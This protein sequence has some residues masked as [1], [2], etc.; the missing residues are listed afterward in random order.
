M[1]NKGFVPPYDGKPSRRV[2]GLQDWVKEINKFCCFEIN[3][4][5]VN[6]F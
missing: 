5:K 2:E 4:Y 1:L 3:D 6:Y